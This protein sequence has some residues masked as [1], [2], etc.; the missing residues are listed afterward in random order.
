MVEL[1]VVL[2]L[3][4]AKETTEIKVRDDCATQTRCGVMVVTDEVMRLY[5]VDTDK[6]PGTISET[7]SFVT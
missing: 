5:A 6:R 4:L 1:V 2:V 3:V 7:V